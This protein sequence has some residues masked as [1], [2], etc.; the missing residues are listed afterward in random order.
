M[1]SG[2]T[3]PE[4]PEKRLCVVCGRRELD[5]T[6]LA[7]CLDC[8]SRTRS[9]LYE[10]V[11]L[12]ARLPELLGHPK[13]TRYDAGRPGGDELP[14]PGG[15]VLVMLAGGSEAKARLRA[16]LRGDDDAWDQDDRSGD[17]P[18]V[19]HVL[20]EW[21][22]SWRR[23]R[24]DKAASGPATVASAAAYLGARMSDAAQRLKSFPEFAGDMRKL[25]GRL[26]A[27]TGTADNPVRADVRCFDCDDRLE[28]RWTDE[29]LAEQWDCPGCGRVYLP[30]EYVLALRAAES[31]A[32]TDIAALRVR[33][34]SVPAGT[35]GQWASKGRLE[36]RGKDHRGRTLYRVGDVVDLLQTLGRTG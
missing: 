1:E 10:I 30:A 11:D 14:M 13:A 32:L 29:G 36:R 16:F 25:A 12:Y 20:S 27:V 2:M 31:E 17:A 19:A 35:F 15:D 34:P 9:A 28:R 18:S 26:R 24:G 7:T 33:F 5:A 6:T 3:E 4:A 8:L 22:D 21:E 23:E